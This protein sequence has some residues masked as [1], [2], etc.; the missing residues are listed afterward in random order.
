MEKMTKLT[1]SFII[2]PV[3]AKTEMA[4]CLTDTAIFNPL[5]AR[6]RLSWRENVGFL[7]RR[8]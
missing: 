6:N 3:I 8:L 2:L 5:K 1:T 7:A 4:L